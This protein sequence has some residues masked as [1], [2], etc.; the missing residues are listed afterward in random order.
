MRKMI[1]IVA[2]F[3]VIGCIAS[4]L[5]GCST[6]TINFVKQDLDI[7]YKTVDNKETVEVYYKDDNNQIPYVS[8]DTYK[9]IS[10]KI[11]ND[12]IG[13]YQE[14]IDYQLTTSYEKDKATLSR[15]NG[16]N[17]IFDFTKNTIYFDN[18]DRF[19]AHSYDVSIQ[20]LPHT[21][22]YDENGNPI[23]IQ[24]VEQKYVYTNSDPITIDLNKYDIDIVY[25]NNAYY[26]PLQT[27]SDLLI[28]MQYCNILYNTQAVYVIDYATTSAEKGDE[29]SGLLAKYYEDKTAVR[30]KEL[31]DY[32]YNELCLL[33]DN[34]YGLKQE[35]M[36]ND[37][38]TY[39]TNT[40]NQG[41][42]LKEYL[43]SEDPYDFELG[44]AYLTNVDFNDLHSSY[45]TASSYAGNIG[46]NVIKQTTAGTG[47]SEL[48][49][50]YSQLSKAK[51]AAYP[52]GMKQYE[53]IGNTAFIYFN[54]FLVSD[55]DYYTEEATIDAADS[56]G[57]LIYAYQQVY[58]ENSPIENVVL[59]LSLNTGGYEN[60]LAYVCG[61][62]TGEY[63]FS[64]VNPISNATSSSR[65]RIDANMDHEFTDEDWF[66]D[67]NL[68][69]ITSPVSF[70]CANICAAILKENTNVTM[71]GRRSGG[72]SNIVQVFTTASG[73]WYQSSGNKKVVRNHIGSFYNVDKGIEV[74]YRFDKIEDFYNR[75]DIVEFINSLH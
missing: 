36:I 29:P 13:D 15:E 1:K 50:V 69:C 22:C 25:E 44:M 2:N 62:F 20:E 51:I 35:H 37:F 28:N 58:R 19:I 63:T 52:D 53:E 7:Y 46:S 67:K 65:Y 43:M 64:I 75:K 47:R 40:I 6:Q 48:L 3:L 45:I 21:S 12:G 66:Y 60:A 39:L 27:L 42:S 11:Y 30:S 72:G 59:D 16:T 71:L 70:S 41:K 33:L 18:Y 55:V 57:L 61:M 74:D 31:I 34:S 17:M 10:N 73:G 26:I 14:D 8:L 5:F 54:N 4:S 24:R 68:Y 32:T 38:D 56:I 49:A 23:Y 9:D